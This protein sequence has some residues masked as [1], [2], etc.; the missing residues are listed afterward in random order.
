LW[1]ESKVGEG[2]TFYLQLPREPQKVA[3]PTGV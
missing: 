2:S 3:A 1:A